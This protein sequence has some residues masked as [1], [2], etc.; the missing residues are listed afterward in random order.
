[1]DNFDSYL[2]ASWYVLCV[3]MHNKICQELLS[4]KMIEVRFPQKRNSRLSVKSTRTT[5]KHNTTHTQTYRIQ[6]WQDICNGDAHTGIK[7]CIEFI[8]HNQFIHPKDSADR[9]VHITEVQL[10][11]K[12]PR[13]CLCHKCLSSSSA[14]L[15]F[16]CTTWPLQTKPKSL[17]N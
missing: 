2:Y 10:P 12:G 7:L 3:L 8:Q 6:T 1:V 13:A 14:S 15:F 5:P 16:N 17:H 11:R 4:V 9:M